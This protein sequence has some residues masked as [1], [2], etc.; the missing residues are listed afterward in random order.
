M[1]SLGAL[2]VNLTANSRDFTAGLAGAEAALNRFVSK[3]SAIALV[4][5]GFEGL[6]E[7]VRLAADFQ[8][9]STQLEVLTGSASAAKK[10]IDELYQLGLESPFGAQD[11]LDSAKILGQF[12]VSLSKTTEL[13]K[14]IG[15][16]PEKLFQ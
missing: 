2:A 4:M 3:A 15:L 11:F 12:G 14:V 7:A 6:T 10:M 16:E 8:L 13:V 5:K 1:A 9:V